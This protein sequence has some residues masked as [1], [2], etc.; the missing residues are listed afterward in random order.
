MKSKYC[1]KENKSFKDLS[2]LEIEN[3]IRPYYTD[4]YPSLQQRIANEM[5]L[6]SMAANYYK[7]LHNDEKHNNLDMVK[8]DK[9]TDADTCVKAYNTMMIQAISVVIGLT[10]LSESVASSIAEKITDELG[11]D[12]LNAL[13]ETIFDLTSSDSLFDRATAF[14]TLVIDA[15]NIISVPV[16]VQ[17]VLNSLDF[18]DYVLY[19]AGVSAQ[20][21]IWLGTDAMALAGELVADAIAVNNL[22]QQ[23]EA[24]IS[25]CNL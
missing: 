2:V 4:F 7:G 10:A 21:F 13:G 17:I 3:A 22:V 20:L 9:V 19:G 1:G 23:A 15:A 5:S 16:F 12:S 8:N 11:E 24:T 14:A 6:S 25:A 18:W